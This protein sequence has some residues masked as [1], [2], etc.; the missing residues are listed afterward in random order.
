MRKLFCLVT[1]LTLFCRT[2]VYAEVIRPLYIEADRVSVTLLI[3]TD[4]TATCR[5][6][7]A[8]KHINTTT[9]LTLSLLCSSDGQTW[10]EV[11]SWSATGSGLLGVSIEKTTSIEKGYQYVVCA[12]GDLFDYSGNHLESVSKTSSVKSF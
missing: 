7:V 5:G 2:V 11:N 3:D 1:I 9:H 4:G 8:A 12:E 6:T 10:H